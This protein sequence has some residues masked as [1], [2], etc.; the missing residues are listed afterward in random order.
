[1]KKIYVKPT[2]QKSLFEGKFSRF[3]DQIVSSVV[4]STTVMHIHSVV[5]SKECPKMNVCIKGTFCDGNVCF[6]LN[7]NVD[8][9]EGVN[10]LLN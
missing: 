7:L 9:V 4:H 5:V 8:G 3:Y 2:Y 1:M 6:N 10:M